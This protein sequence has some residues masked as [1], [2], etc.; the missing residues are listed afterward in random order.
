MHLDQHVLGGVAGRDNLYRQRRRSFNR[1]F[2]NIQ[3]FKLLGGKK[4][5]VGTA[6]R[7]RAQAKICFIQ[8]QAETMDLDEITQGAP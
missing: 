6:H 4:G 8:H 1:R 7:V 3:I 2:L 5:D